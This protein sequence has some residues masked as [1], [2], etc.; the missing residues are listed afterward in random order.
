MTV[1]IMEP[2]RTNIVNA[3]KD[4]YPVTGAGRVVLSLS[5]SLFN[6]LLS[7]KLM[8]IGQAIKEFNYVAL[9]YLIVCLLLDI[10]TKEIIGCDTKRRRL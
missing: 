2:K 10:L 4:T 7:N 5:L 3:N 1:E 6:T 9:I 8:S